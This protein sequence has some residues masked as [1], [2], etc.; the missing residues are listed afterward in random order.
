MATKV[1]I[2]PNKIV[3]LD[4]KVLAGLCVRVYIGVMT[5]TQYLAHQKRM[6]Y[7]AT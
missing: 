1:V 3:Y 7:L 5:S 2:F 4:S 6:V